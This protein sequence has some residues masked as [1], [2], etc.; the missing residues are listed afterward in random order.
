M[1]HDWRSNVDNWRQNDNVLVHFY[2][3]FSFFF[4]SFL[5]F[6]QYSFSSS[7]FPITTVHLQ[8][9]TLTRGQR[10]PG[11]PQPSSVDGW[12]SSQ[13]TSIDRPSST[14]SC[15]D[16]PSLHHI[17]ADWPLAHHQISASA[18][19]PSRTRSRACQISR[20]NVG[21]WVV[22]LLSSRLNGCFSFNSTLPRIPGYRLIAPISWF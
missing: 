12:P 7:L 2:F 19:Q 4:F 17:S 5:C 18:G 14:K 15:A 21:S 10:R 16:W 13:Q 8:V 1:W 6:S 11:K 20:P 22:K 3:Q 9:I